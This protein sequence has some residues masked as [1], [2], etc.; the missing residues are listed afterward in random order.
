MHPEVGWGWAG[1]AAGG[2][3]QRMQR[4]KNSAQENCVA[5]PA[6]VTAIAFPVL[7]GICVSRSLHEVGVELCG[8]RVFWRNSEM[9]SCAEASAVVAW[10]VEGT[11]HSNTVCV[12]TS[13]V[14]PT[15]K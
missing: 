8:G 10:C 15:R 7:L 9:E 1:D 12:R 6:N 13:G 14:R 2:A 4:S 3:L 5:A 11:E